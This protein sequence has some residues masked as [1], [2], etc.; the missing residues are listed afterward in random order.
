M[1]KSSRLYSAAAMPASTP[2]TPSAEQ[3]EPTA[4]VATDAGPTIV[5]DTNVVLDCLLFRDPGCKALMASLEAGHLRWL[6]SAAMRDEL[7]H[8]LARG[9]LGA[10]QPDAGA[11]LAAWDRWS[12]PAPDALPPATLRCSDPDDQ[13]FIDV[14]VT[15]QA[16]W[17]LS[18]D[19]AVLRLAPA[20]RRA[21]LTILT[22]VAWAAAN[23]ASG[24]PTRPAP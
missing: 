3:G 21:G 11:L 15:Q 23:D 9:H 14:A 1:L 2:P 5:L 6:A 19:K 10:W 16:R 7:A 4:D 8:V 12:L 24:Q 17:L 20:A 13:K 18:R 22:P